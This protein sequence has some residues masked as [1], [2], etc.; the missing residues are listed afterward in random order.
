[1]L[2]SGVELVEE[3]VAGGASEWRV[4]EP[5]QRASSLESRVSRGVALGGRAAWRLWGFGAE[6]GRGASPAYVGGRSWR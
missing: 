5:R 3:S 1:V 4:P 2:G 6:G